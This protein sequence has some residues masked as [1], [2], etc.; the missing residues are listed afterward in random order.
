MKRDA[1][2]ARGPGRA[3]SGLSHKG[4]PIINVCAG[5]IVCIFKMRFTFRRE[6]SLST[7]LLLTPIIGLIV[8]VVAAYLLR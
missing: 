1:P 8:V 5:L 3:G 2:R 6:A 4:D 7:M